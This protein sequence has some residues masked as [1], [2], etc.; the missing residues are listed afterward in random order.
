MRNDNR[1][2]VG[3]AM[4]RDQARRLALVLLAVVSLA[5]R[6]YP[7]VTENL[8]IIWTIPDSTL[9]GLGTDLASGDVNG[10]GIPDIVA[11]WDTFDSNGGSTPLRGIVN[12]YYG[13][14][15]GETIPDVVLKSPVWKGANAPWLACGDL[16]GD[17][18]ADVAI[19]EDMVDRGAGMC[20]VFMGGNPM[21]TTPAF[22]IHGK[23]SWWLDFHF[24]SD[25]SIG[26]VNGDGYD[27]LAVGAYS[28]AESPGEQ[29]TGRVYVFYGGPGFDTIPD[30]TLRGG[31]DGDYEGFGISVTAQGDFDH[32]GF[33]DL[34]IGAWQYGSDARGRMY[35][36]Y[37][38]NPM[39]TSYDMA[40]S[41]EGV[42]HFLGFERPGALKA[43]GTFDY[44]VEGNE[45]WPHGAYNP[46]ANCG[47]VYVHQGGQP[48]D[49]IPDEEIIGPMDSANLGYTA[50]S[51]GDVTGDGNDDLVAGA[52]YLPPCASGGAYL[53]ET[54]NHF[55]TVPDAWM[56][57]EPNRKVGM[58]VCTAGD[59]DGDGRSEFLVGTYTYIPASRIWVCKYT[60][61]G[62]EEEKQRPLTSLRLDVAPNPA[63][64]AFLVRYEVTSPSRV[65]VGLY[66]VGGRLVRSLSEGEV[67]PGRYEAKLPSGVLPA[68]VYICTLDNGATRISRKV[69][70]TE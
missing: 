67:A 39:D 30:V 1:S 31:H 53:W 51:A 20:T 19:S 32:D 13:D 17:G 61:L 16:N 68:G 52:P 23:S 10:D 48:M 40:M 24:G 26:D 36:Y 35:V 3:R 58:R 2:A 66:D 65:S 15:I 8:D 22:I 47:K 41:G 62:I 60:G 44:A 43:Q 14:H 34:Y 38:G 4:L 42:G 50:Q 33:H 28:T 11:A 69:V 9:E 5:G 18:Y 54:G 21:D 12:I 64:G 55:D 56:M 27:D 6:A 37:G 29:G 45:L 70:L 59:I 57:G 46:G 7:L 49:S 63:R 25:V